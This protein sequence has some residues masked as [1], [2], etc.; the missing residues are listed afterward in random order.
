MNVKRKKFSILLSL[1][2]VVPVLV[3]LFS[4]SRSLNRSELLLDFSESFFKQQGFPKEIMHKGEAYQVGYTIDSKLQY[5]IE[6]LLKRFKTP[7]S[8]VV[9]IDNNSG[10]IISALGYDYG[11]KKILKELAFTATHPAASLFKIVSAASIMSDSSRGPKT[12]YSYIGKGTTL[13]KY[14]L[15][16][17][18]NK[19]PK[20]ISLGKAFSTSNNVVFG[21]AAIDH[22]SKND[23]FNMAEKFKFNQ[24]IIS[25]LDLSPSRFG[26]ASD[27]YNLAEFASGFNKETTISPLHAAFLSYLIANKGQSKKL[28]ILENITSKDNE[29]EVMN[30]SKRDIK[31]AIEK[32][33]AENIFEMMQ[34]TVKR[35]TA[36]KSFSSLNRKLRK[37]LHIGGKTGSITG[38]FPYGKHE[39]FT[40]FAIPKDNEEDRGISISVLN[41]LEQRWYV[42]SAYIAKNIIE[43]YYKKIRKEQG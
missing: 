43:F 32:R 37:S 12:R 21:K 3:F 27:Q 31:Q 34:L 10:N 40:A 39:W 8:V 33:I 18:K 35:G 2:L 13:Y 26:L 28:T 20:K 41:I 38:G 16:K 7:Y 29:V 24:K 19:W 5:Y 9:V 17:K 14:Q 4:S 6:G 42:R 1:L 23:L 25:E 15:K 30:S 22:I 11:Q 36:R